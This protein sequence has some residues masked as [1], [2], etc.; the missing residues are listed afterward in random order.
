MML[1]R[2]DDS[3]ENINKSI[4]FKRRSGIPLDVLLRY[5]QKAEICKYFK[6]YDKDIECWNTLLDESSRK[7]VKK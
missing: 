2:Y 6:K 1:N 4:E 7:F 3:M 5:E